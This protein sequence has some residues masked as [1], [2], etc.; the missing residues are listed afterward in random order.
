LD[1]D[2]HTGIII[3][4]GI[5]RIVK[6]GE[7]HPA[8]LQSSS[9]EA[10]DLKLFMQHIDDLTKHD[11]DSKYVRERRQQLWKQLF[12]SSYLL[13]GSFGTDARQNCFEYGLRSAIQK[14]QLIVLAVCWVCW[15]PME[16]YS[17]CKHIICKE[18]IAEKCLFCALL[19]EPIEESEKRLHLDDFAGLIVFLKFLENN[20]N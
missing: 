19:H 1:H 12:Q 11:F 3:C 16:E 15:R 18:C 2:R 5:Q 17:T 4:D 8:E 14:K 10:E 13:K 20:R 9:S 6:W 7:G